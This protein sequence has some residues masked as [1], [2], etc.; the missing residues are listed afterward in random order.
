MET[1]SIVGRHGRIDIEVL[2][3]LSDLPCTGES[4][5]GPYPAE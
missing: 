4:L 2:K 1:I 3:T 5:F